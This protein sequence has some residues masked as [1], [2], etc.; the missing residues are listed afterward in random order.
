MGIPVHV[1][2]VVIVAHGLDDIAARVIQLVDKIR[3]SHVGTHT[4]NAHGVELA[5][6]IDAI[7][8]AI[9]G[10]AQRQQLCAILRS[11]DG[12]DRVHKDLSIPF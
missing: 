10:A 2:G 8:A 5:L 9:G 7:K 4:V 12:S 1:A 3:G 6:G 11:C